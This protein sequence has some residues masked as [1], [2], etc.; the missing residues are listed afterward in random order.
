MAG[1]GTGRIK[2]LVA[3]GI[4]A[5]VALW[6]VL[7]RFPDLFLGGRIWAEEGTSFLGHIL[8]QKA[9]GHPIPWLYLHHGHWDVWTTLTALVAAQEPRQASRIFTWFSLIPHA[10][11]CLA[12]LRYSLLRLAPQRPSSGVSL[13]LGSAAM[14]VSL[15]AGGP[16]VFATT[17]NSQWI[18]SIYVFFTLLTSLQKDARPFAPQAKTCRLS[19]GLAGLD[20]L[21]MLSSF[22]AVVLLPIQI[23]VMTWRAP[24]SNTSGWQR[25]SGT[26]AA[27]DLC[28][29]RPGLAMGFLIQI[30]ST[31]LLVSSSAQ[32]RSLM[33]PEATRGFLVQGLFGLWIPWRG[34]LGAMASSL[35]ASGDVSP[36]WML[37][38]WLIAASVIAAC[39][40]AMWMALR[41]DWRP[42]LVLLVMTFVLTNLALGDKSLLTNPGD[43]MRYFAPERIGMAWLLVT[44][45]MLSCQ[46]RLNLS[47]LDRSGL[48]A[49]ALSLLIGSSSITTFMDA[50]LKAM[51]L[52]PGGCV[53]T[54][55]QVL[56]RSKGSW[57]SAEAPIPICPQGWVIPIP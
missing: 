50:D 30:I 20:L 38:G 28:R 9:M 31:L 18:L 4:G 29:R 14:L 26:R 45:V 51:G 48:Y 47:R 3:A 22:A 53:T 12:M 42:A 10:I 13:G 17:T 49:L 33:V 55:R 27:I 44:R 8:Q 35:Q 34:A 11:A 7:L 24:G 52:A 25:N 36:A 57:T 46:G 56:A 23:G 2:T 43:G 19:W 32:D 54:T 15:L 40:L 41:E 37:I 39:L 16:E 1:S 5:T 21:V 6:G